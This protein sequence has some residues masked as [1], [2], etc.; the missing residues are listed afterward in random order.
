MNYKDALQITING[1]NWVNELN[2]LKKKQHLIGTK[3]AKLKK[4]LRDNHKSI[5]NAKTFIKQRDKYIHNLNEKHP[6]V[7]YISGYKM[8]TH[9][10]T[11]SFKVLLKDKKTQIR[12]F[13]SS[14]DLRKQSWRPN[15]E[16]KSKSLIYK[17]DL[18]KWYPLAGRNEKG[19]K[20]KT[21]PIL[22]TQ[23]KNCGKTFES[24][25]GA[26]C[27][28]EKCKKRINNLRAQKRKDSRTERAKSNGKY[29][30]SIT[31]EKV[32]KK[33]KGICYICGK[34]LILDHI[35]Y[36][37]PD[38]PTIEHVIPICRGGTHTWGNVKLACRQCNINKSRKTYQEY[39][40]QEAS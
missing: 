33:E 13:A 22:F 12:F 20:T 16:S 30:S 40:K 2:I 26:T 34:H 24:K 4:R 28:S 35:N 27:C 14:S 39:L 15:I 7:E 10:E 19:I 3:I 36:N 8:R 32:Y 25:W 21:R 17:E 37:R 9:T 38:A 18:Q 11:T 29:D 6:E 1:Q 31:L 5:I 23:C